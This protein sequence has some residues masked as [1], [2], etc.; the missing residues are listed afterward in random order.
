M[1]GR[2]RERHLRSRGA[3]SQMMRV[4]CGGLWE[5]LWVTVSEKTG[6]ESRNPFKILTFKEM[7]DVL[8]LLQGSNLRYIMLVNLQRQM[9]PKHT[10]PPILL[11]LQFASFFIFS[12]SLIRHLCLPRF[13][14]LASGVWRHGQ[15]WQQLQKNEIKKYVYKKTKGTQPLHNDKSLCYLK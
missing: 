13:P 1:R 3:Q 14:F 8:N 15:L 11:E 7:R 12:S 5:H 4:K 9:L 10:P 2:W 6:A